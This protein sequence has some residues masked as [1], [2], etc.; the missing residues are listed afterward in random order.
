MKFN[1]NISCEASDNEITSIIGKCGEMVTSI[2]SA[3]NNAVGGCDN[4]AGIC[5]A[6][7]GC[8]TDSLDK[9]TSDD[10]APATTDR[11]DELKKRCNHVDKLGRSMLLADTDSIVCPL[12][13]KRW[14][15]AN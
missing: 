9:T 13:G 14:V 10:A 7:C 12:C 4:D 5:N 8:D 6:C 2:Y 11:V 3:I 15:S 1:F